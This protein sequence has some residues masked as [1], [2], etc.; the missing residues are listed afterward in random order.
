MDA[1]KELFGYD[2]AEVN[3][4]LEKVQKDKENK[5]YEESEDELYRSSMTGTG[6]PSQTTAYGL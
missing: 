3:K 6:I 4:K 2:F 5:V 1:I